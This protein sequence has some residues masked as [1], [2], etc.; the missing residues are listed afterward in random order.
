MSPNSIAIAQFGSH[1]TL[2]MI[3][4]LS[5]TDRFK[6]V[7]SITFNYVPTTEPTRLQ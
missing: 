3:A 4:E 7:G 6:D 1:W 5:V 2:S